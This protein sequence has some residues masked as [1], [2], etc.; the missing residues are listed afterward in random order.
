V[1]EYEPN[2]HHSSAIISGVKQISVFAE[3]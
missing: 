3:E 1:S 2:P